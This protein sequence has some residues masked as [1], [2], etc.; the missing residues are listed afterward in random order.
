MGFGTEHVLLCLK[1][2]IDS[3]DLH[4]VRG[5]LISFH[6]KLKHQLSSFD[7]AKKIEDATSKDRSM[8]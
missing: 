1:V 3:F 2:L 7:G 5:L 6:T 8:H 4:T